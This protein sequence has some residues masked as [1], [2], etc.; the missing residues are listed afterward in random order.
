M[1]Y[2]KY[3]KYKLKYLHLKNQIGGVS[4]EK[5]K[6]EIEEI[7]K[8][9]KILDIEMIEKIKQLKDYDIHIEGYINSLKSELAY[10]NEYKKYFSNYKY[11]YTS[12][13]HRLTDTFIEKIN[14]IEE[15]LQEEELK[16]DPK[17]VY[18]VLVPGDSGSKLLAIDQLFQTNIDKAIDNKLYYCTFPLS[19]IIEWREK[20][21][22]YLDKIIDG[23]K[24]EKDISDESEIIFG[25]FDTDC[26][27]T[28]IR[29]LGEYLSSKKYNIDY[30]PPVDYPP[31]LS[32]KVP[33]RHEFQGIFHCA[34]FLKSGAQPSRCVKQ[35]TEED[36]LIHLKEN[37][38]FFKHYIEENIY[39]NQ[40]ILVAWFYITK[41]E[42]IRKENFIG[43]EGEVIVKK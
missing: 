30:F 36:Y 5:F 42:E 6:S 37:Y 20:L 25:L 28:T 13:H 22:E 35:F 19:R 23:F 9:K 14:E 18:I 8:E 7:L 40:Y 15:E 24:K 29:I 34:E 38:Q 41:M 31:K 12:K 21:Y 11:D 1:D 27:G 32:E 2:K 33:M 26:G 16:P 43:V 4:H 3:I 17:R 10:Y 39:C